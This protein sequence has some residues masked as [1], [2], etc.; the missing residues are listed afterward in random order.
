VRPE[1]EISFRSLQTFG[2]QDLAERNQKQM[3]EYD[4]LLAKIHSILLSAK[5]DVTIKRAIVGKMS[6]LSTDLVSSIRAIEARFQPQELLYERSVKTVLK[7]YE[8]CLNRLANHLAVAVSSP[9]TFKRMLQEIYLDLTK[10]SQWLEDTTV[11]LLQL[12]TATDLSRASQQRNEM[13]S[14]HKILD[15]VEKAVDEE[16]ES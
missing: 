3:L 4:Y 7:T 8:T 11:K 9:E 16:R 12:P 15:R 10:H 6:I 5:L 1:T 14:L 13:E 2:I